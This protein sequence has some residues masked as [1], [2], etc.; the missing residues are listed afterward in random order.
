[1]DLPRTRRWTPA[2][3]IRPDAPV[4]ARR[5]IEVVAREARRLGRRFR[6]TRDGVSFAK[7]EA[8]RR[9]YDGVLGEG[10]DALGVS[11]LLAVLPAGEELDHERLRVERTLH[12]WGMVLDDAG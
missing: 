7:S 2:R 4:P 5:E 6:A 9:A 10:C 12:R 3:L 1:M 11:H 8:Y